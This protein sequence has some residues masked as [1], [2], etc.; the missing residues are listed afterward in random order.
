MNTV[1]KIDAQFARMEQNWAQ[2]RSGPFPERARIALAKLRASLEEVPTPT[3]AATPTA[4]STTTTTT[5]PTAPVPTAPVATPAS[6][7]A[8]TDPSRNAVS[9]A[10]KFSNTYCCV[11]H[12]TEVYIMLQSCTSWEVLLRVSLSREVLLQFYFNTTV[13]F[14]SYYLGHIQIWQMITNRILFRYLIALFPLIPNQVISRLSLL[15]IAPP[16]LPGLGAH[17]KKRGYKE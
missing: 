11:T 5:T 7:T 8:A 3:S 17:K 1:E 15:A 2:T 13:I 6:P 14:I 16:A 9:H 4:T 10:S 12:R